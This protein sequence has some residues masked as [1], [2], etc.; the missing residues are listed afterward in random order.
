MS[1]AGE[2]DYIIN[3]YYVLGIETCKSIVSRNCTSELSDSVFNLVRAE[4]FEIKNVYF[5]S[6]PQKVLLHVLFSYQRFQK[7]HL[8]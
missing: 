8:R 6:W 2:V 1:L 3:L 5:G 7:D 4:K